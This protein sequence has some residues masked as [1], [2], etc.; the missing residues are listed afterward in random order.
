MP[1]ELRVVE[2]LL[3]VLHHLTL[4]PAV[5][6]RVQRIH[7]LGVRAHSGSEHCGVDLQEFGGVGEGER[8]G[9]E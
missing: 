3:H 6:Q 8:K 4:A 1:L 9:I 7:A 5:N 2:V